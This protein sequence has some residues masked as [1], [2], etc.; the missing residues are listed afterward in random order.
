MGKAGWGILFMT[1]LSLGVA[2]SSVYMGMSVENSISS[3]P[4][5]DKFFQ[6]SALDEVGN[7]EGFEYALYGYIDT[8][9]S[10]L[11]SGSEDFYSSSFVN[12]KTFLS[13]FKGFFAPATIFS[14]IDGF[15]T[16]L[17]WIISIIWSIVFALLT[18]EVIWRF[19]IFD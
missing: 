5:L 3:N 12:T 7:S 11:S 9:S 4:T 15:P 10:G 18:F 6:S 1:L 2:V 16:S 14:S 13:F 17:I 19:N 8:N